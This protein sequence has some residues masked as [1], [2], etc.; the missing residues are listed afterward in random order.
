MLQALQGDLRVLPP[1]QLCHVWLLFRNAFASRYD[2]HCCVNSRQPESPALS[3][4][5]SHSWLAP[6][7]MPGPRGSCGVPSLG[8]AGGGCDGRVLGAFTGLTG[9]SGWASLKV[10][11]IEKGCGPSG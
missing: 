8:G 10:G 11:Q 1:D 9:K 7:C 4:C 6:C 3:L 5:G 2:S